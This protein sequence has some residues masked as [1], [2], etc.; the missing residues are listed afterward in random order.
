MN[1]KNCMVLGST[2]F[3]L[4]GCSKKQK[5]TEGTALNISGSIEIN[6]KLAAHTQA[7]DV[8]FL[9]ARPAQGGPPLAVKKITGNQYPYTF[10]LTQSDLMIP[11]EVPDT[12]INLTIRVDK[13]GDA[14]TK[15]RGDMIGSYINNPIA[16]TAQNIVVTITEILK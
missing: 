15:R 11:Q 12:P 4:M 6:S 13:D 3:L 8:I 2:L 14:L 1:I 9:I 5:E 10:N 16:L 7:S